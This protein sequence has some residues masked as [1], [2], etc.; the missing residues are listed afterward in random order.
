MIKEDVDYYLSNSQGDKES[1]LGRLQHY[2]N[3]GRAHNKN[4]SVANLK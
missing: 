2:I 1:A 4:G 3:Q